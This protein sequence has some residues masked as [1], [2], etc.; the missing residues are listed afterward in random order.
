MRKT[1]AI[2]LTLALTATT[3]SARQLG[4]ERTWG[5]LDEDGAE[6]V[7]VATD[8]SVY[9]TGT[10]LSFGVGDR[11][12]FLLKYAADGTLV[13]QR[14]WATARTE[15]FLRA[16]DH[17]TD[18]A[19]AAGD[20]SIYVTGFSGDDAFL[21]KFGAAGML[22][23]Q[24][25]WGGAFA[26][27][28]EGVAVAADGSVYVTGATDGFGDAFL[29]KFSDDG[30]LLWQKRWGGEGMDFAHD[31]AIA[32]DG[33]LYIAGETNSFFANDAFLAKF[34][35]GGTL[36]WDRVWRDGTIEDLSGA[37]GVA[38]AA[39]GSV[40]LTGNAS[41]NLV[42]QDIF[43]VKFTPEGGLLFEKTWGDRLSSANGVAV[44]TDGTICVTGG[45]GL[46]QGNG[47]A[48]VVRFLPNGKVAQ[49]S[50]WGG[51]ENDLGQSIA[52]GPE[53]IVYV[54][55]FAGAPPYAFD[56]T[57]RTTKRPDGFLGVPGGTVADAGGIVGEATGVVTTPA[58]S[59]TFGGAID[60]A[61]VKVL[62]S[63]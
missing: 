1:F 25:T 58:G 23:W 19:V 45:T 48:F 51:T 36:L 26:D 12:V 18:V 28:A 54:A 3:V 61:L 22:Q 40:Y 27:F 41:I 34:D 16:D 9:S 49:A 59:E 60:A 62:P 50:T 39:D 6:G 5:G 33:S 55:G 8:G 31:I 38:V 52:A 56:R 42:G 10:T 15:P 46:G 32:P 30:V 14:T 17:A 63:R 29:V 20:G 47:D 35:A 21:L 57:R 11:D 13:W 24:K 7:A 4:F 43:L 53:G 44:A 37:F 2:S